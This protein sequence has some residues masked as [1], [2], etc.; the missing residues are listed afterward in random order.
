MSEY[1]FAYL[2]KKMDRGGEKVFIT[3]SEGK[4]EYRV[5]NDS[6]DISSLPLLSYNVILQ[7][8]SGKYYRANLFS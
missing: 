6:T 2:G 3:Y 7:V 1:H 4:G 8:G 5:I